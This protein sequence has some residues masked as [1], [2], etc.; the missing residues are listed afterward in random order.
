MAPSLCSL[1]LLPS[2]FFI[3]ALAYKLFT[4]ENHILVDHQYKTISNF[5]FSKCVKACKSERRC[6]SVNFEGSLLSKGCCVL[7]GCGVENEEDKG[8]SL[9]F[10][11]G[12]L[13]HQVRS[14]EAAIR[15]VWT[16]MLCLCLEP[17]YIDDWK[18]FRVVFFL[19]RGFYKNTSLKKCPKFWNMLRTYQRLRKSEELLF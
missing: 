5:K 8:K 19:I 6:I 14:T 3:Q 13:F 10:S 2:C 7:N 9:V 16:F 11:P 1:V 12:C 4:V 15:K 18:C 17:T